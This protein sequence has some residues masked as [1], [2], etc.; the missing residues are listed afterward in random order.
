MPESIFV[1][2]IVVNGVVSPVELRAKAETHSA[3]HPHNRCGLFVCLKRGTAVMGEPLRRSE[4]VSQ[5]RACNRGND[6]AILRGS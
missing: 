2:S 1:S 6:F 5:K 4:T 3:T